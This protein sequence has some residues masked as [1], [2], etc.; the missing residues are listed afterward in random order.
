MASIF[1]QANWPGQGWSGVGDSKAQGAHKHIG[2]GW[3]GGGVRGIELS[4][5]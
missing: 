2:P 4:E 1:D 3:K 5:I